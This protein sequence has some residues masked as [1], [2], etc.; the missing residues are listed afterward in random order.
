MNWEVCDTHEKGGDLQRLLRELLC[1]PR[2]H[3][4]QSLSGSCLDQLQ[5][6]L[7]LPQKEGPYRCPMGGW[8]AK[9]S[10]AKLCCL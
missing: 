2:I 1:D 5:Q 9:E 3:E 4:T 8:L 10:W 7:G 6:D